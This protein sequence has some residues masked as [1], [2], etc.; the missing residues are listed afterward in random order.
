M[1][2]GKERLK[3]SWKWIVIALV[4]I[5]LAVVALGCREKGT[6]E[7]VSE[8]GTWKAY[9]FETK[10]DGKT[11]W[12]GAL[13][14]SGD[15]PKKIKNVRTQRCV[16]GIKGDFVK[17]GLKDSGSANIGRGDIGGADQYYVFM[18]KRDTKPN[19]LS[20]KV[21]WKEGKKNKVEKLWLIN[22]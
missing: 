4:I 12:T 19:S 16:N 2:N 17:R 7:A 22:Q 13:V 18:P 5:V 14:Y 8:D 15:K 1:K 10:V 20:V 6:M 21:K 3:K 11:V 9:A